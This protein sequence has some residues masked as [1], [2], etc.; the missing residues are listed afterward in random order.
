MKRLF[1]K[2]F[3]II[4]FRLLVKCELYNIMLGKWWFIF[5][6]CSVG[7]VKLIY[8]KSIDLPTLSDVRIGNRALDGLQAAGK[9]QLRVVQDLAQAHDAQPW[10]F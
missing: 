9:L 6:A 3:I 5:R 2:L 8:G 4:G 7:W 10:Q 1:E